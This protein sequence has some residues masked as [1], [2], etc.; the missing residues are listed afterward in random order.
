M[1]FEIVDSWCD[2][3]GLDDLI[4][5]YK[6][7]QENYLSKFNDEEIENIYKENMKV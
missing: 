3:M 5:F 2:A 7:E 6:A 1:I 4:A